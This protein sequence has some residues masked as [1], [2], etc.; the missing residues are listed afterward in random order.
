MNDT[1]YPMNDVGNGMR[2]VRDHQ[3]HVRWLIDEQEWCVWEGTHWRRYRTD[4][5]VVCWRN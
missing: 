1:P 4:E 3:Q 2:F 5:K